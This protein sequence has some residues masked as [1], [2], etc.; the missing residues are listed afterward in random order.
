MK[1]L[2]VGP[3]GVG[4]THIATGLGAATVQADFLHVL[5]IGR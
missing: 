4:K 5:R 3:P 1:V 2:V